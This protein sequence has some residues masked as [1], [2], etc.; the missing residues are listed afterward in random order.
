MIESVAGMMS[1]PPTPMTA[2]AP[3]STPVEFDSAATIEPKPKMAKPSCNA[4][5]RP[6]RS[7]RLP[8]VSSRPANTKV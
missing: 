7:P 1:A 6:N 4:P 3:M 2:R 8:A 5:R